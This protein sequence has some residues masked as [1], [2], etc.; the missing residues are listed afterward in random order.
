MSGIRFTLGCLLLLCQLY[1]FVGV[2]L[3]MVSDTWLHWKTGRCKHYGLPL[4]DLPRGLLS[5][6]RMMLTWPVNTKEKFFG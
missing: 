2:M 6:F 5:D 4:R 3:F 1:F